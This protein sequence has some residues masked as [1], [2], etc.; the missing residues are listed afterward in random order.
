MSTIVSSSDVT[1]MCYSAVDRNSFENV[2]SFWI[3]EI[4][5]YNKKKPLVLVA[6]Q[7]DLREENNPEHITDS[8]GQ[9]LT[10]Q[11]RAK[12]YNKCSATVNFGMKNVF[13]SA[14]L[15]SVKFKKK[16]TNIFQRV[17]WR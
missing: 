13:E 12:Y 10:R 3:A 2:K 15:A 5:K 7:S 4:R 6:T 9:E 8:E 11:I 1:V 14:V 16:K 17:F